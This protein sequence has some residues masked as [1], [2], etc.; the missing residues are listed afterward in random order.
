MAVHDPPPAHAEHAGIR[1]RRDGARR[2]NG[3]GSVAVL[4]FRILFVTLQPPH[5]N[6]LTKN[7]FSCLF[8]VT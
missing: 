4:Q 2:C 8:Q 3:G 5:V 6:L 7:F 1:T